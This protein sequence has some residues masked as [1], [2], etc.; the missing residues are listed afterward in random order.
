MGRKI[1]P[2]GLRRKVV[3]ISLPLDV[4][5]HLDK[6]VLSSNSRL[7]R[8][9]HIE[10]LIRDS[11]LKGQA[12]LDIDVNGLRWKWYCS[13]CERLFHVNKETPVMRCKCGVW[14]DKEPDCLGSFDPM[15]E[16]E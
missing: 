5:A 13:K 1:K 11:M 10:K 9:R 8:S 6:L 4:I 12:T 16:E 2:I 3:S 7:T 15:E 14:L